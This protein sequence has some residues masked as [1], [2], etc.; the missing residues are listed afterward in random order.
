MTQNK[1]TITQAEYQKMKKKLTD[2][3]K[4]HAPNPGKY[5]YFGNILDVDGVYDED[6]FGGTDLIQLGIKAKDG[7][8]YPRWVNIV[9]WCKFAKK[10]EWREGK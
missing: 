2:E 10:L 3:G 8:V 1:K 9:V 6:Y 7:K 4:L 5:R